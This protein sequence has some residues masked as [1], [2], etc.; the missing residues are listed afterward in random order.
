MFAVNR[1]CERLEEV[2][3][4]SWVSQ[5]LVSGVLGEESDKHML[6]SKVIGKTDYGLYSYFLVK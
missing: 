4:A 3:N 5:Y 6:R 1:G 2:R